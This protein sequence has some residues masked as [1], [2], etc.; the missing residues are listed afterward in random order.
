VHAA[1]AH[2]AFG[3]GLDSGAQGPQGC[4]RV[5]VQRPHMIWMFRSGLDDNLKGAGHEYGSSAKDGSNEKGRC[6]EPAQ[7]ETHMGSIR[8]PAVGPR[9]GLGKGFFSHRSAMRIKQP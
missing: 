4:P 9:L 7:A 1:D 5:P 2:K 8:R 3:F 6:V